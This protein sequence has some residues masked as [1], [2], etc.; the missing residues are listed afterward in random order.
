MV[1]LGQQHEVLK[2]CMVY[3][4]R[5]WKVKHSLIYRQFIKTSHTQ[6]VVVTVLY[7]SE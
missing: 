2:V 4:D 5:H 7:I 3:W 1:H 6:Q